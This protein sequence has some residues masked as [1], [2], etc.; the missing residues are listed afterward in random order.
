L[1]ISALPSE[2]EKT[3][4]LDRLPMAEAI[5]NRKPVW[6]NTLPDWGVYAPTLSRFPIPDKASTLIALPILRNGLPLG[7]IGLFCR[8]SVT[9]SKE[10]ED[11]LELTTAILA[12]AIEGNQKRSMIANQAHFGE[13]I[14]HTE[15]WDSSL[16]ERQ[17]IVLDLVSN[18]FTNHAIADQLG[19]SVSTVRHE[20]IK[21][22]AALQRSSRREAGDIYRSKR[23]SFSPISD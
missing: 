16:T 20:T 14:F 12:Q 6:V 23:D 2:L 13:H 7:S 8:K 3:S 9:P 19:Y 15:K 21:I 1:D 18:G 5:K 4:I 11:F 10:L 17:M 22:F